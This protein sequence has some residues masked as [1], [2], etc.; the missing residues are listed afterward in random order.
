MSRKVGKRIGG[1]VYIHRSILPHEDYSPIVEDA[2]SILD[3]DFH[4][5]VIKI[6]KKNSSVS[7]IQCED[8]NTAHEPTVGDSYK[9]N[10][11]TGESKLRKARVKNKQIYHHKWMFVNDDYT[12]F[13]IEEAKQRSKSWENSSIEYDPKRIGNFDYWNK[14]VLSKLDK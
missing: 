13:D 11:E 10:V 6:D 3:Q 14:V 2:L 12:G 5:E 7:F 8:W 4:F 1:V 9:V